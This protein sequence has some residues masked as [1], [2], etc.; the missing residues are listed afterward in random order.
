M[1][2]GRTLPNLATELKR[3]FDAKRDFKV[4]TQKLL[5]VPTKSGIQMQLAASGEALTLNPTKH[6]MRQIGTYQKIPADYFDRMASENPDLLAANV[7]SWFNLKPEVR[8]VRT[9]DNKLRAFL[10]DRYRVVDNWDV[11]SAVLPMLF[12]VPEMKIVSCELTESRV[13]IKAVFP[14][15]QAEIRKGDVVQSGVMISNSEVGLGAAN[16][17]PFVERLVCTNGMVASEFGQRRNHVGKQLEM[18]GDNAAEIYRDETLEMS[19]KAFLMRV[20]DTV[21]ACITDAKFKLIVDRMKA[22]TEMKIE[23]PVTEVVEVAAKRWSFTEGEKG[24]ILNHLIAGA[25]LSAYGLLNAITRSAQD[26]DDYDRSTQMEKIGGSILELQ[27]AEWRAIAVKPE[28][29][30]TKALQLAA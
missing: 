8:M 29:K 20:Q 6:A 4:P 28:L 15:I 3:Q 10:S 5:A 16:I 30:T 19:D 22:A 21:K 2:P 1:L 14:R 13:Y 9:L 18:D 12:E 11:A 17:D 23:A 25:D 26:T 27:P 7:N 24:N